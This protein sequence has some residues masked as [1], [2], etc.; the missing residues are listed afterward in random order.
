MKAT[1]CIPTRNQVQY[2]EQSVVSACNQ[3]MS[4]LVHVSDDASTDM[5]PE[6]LASLCQMHPSLRQTRHEINL[7]L[8]A[9][10]R[11][12][13]QG[14]STPYVAIL[15]S[16]DHLERAYIEKLVELLEANPRAGYAHADAHEIDREGRV[17]KRR[18]LSRVPG[19]QGPEE[20]LRSMATGYRVAANICL[21]R[22]EALRNVG[23]HKNDMNFAEDWDLA[24]RLADAGWG[25]VYSNEVLASY[26]VWSDTAG[27]REGRKATEL[28]GIRRVFSESLE[29]AFASRG[30]NAT[31]LRRA[32]RKLALNHALFLCRVPPE[33][34]EYRKLLTL[35]MELGDS[36]A[37]RWK[38]KAIGAGLGPL[39]EAFTRIRGSA[40]RGGK[41]LLFR[42]GLL[43]RPANLA[44][45]TP[46]PGSRQG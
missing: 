30:W 28:A 2:L 24:V 37:L 33:S 44:R 38:I 27:Y 10:H 35:L 7:G 46:D 43:S 6:L 36:P 9:N 34:E 12:L 45:G 16:D 42:S 15:H 22:T 21:F 39:L 18:Y 25:N 5:T 32:R 19:Y 31:M 26:R 17:I 20:S 4:C 14:V 40:L 11:W 1:I 23:F 8:A 13:L 29:P 3:T 41:Q